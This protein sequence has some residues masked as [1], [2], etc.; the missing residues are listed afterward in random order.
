MNNIEVLTGKF[1]STLHNKDNWT[2]NDLLLPDLVSQECVTVCMEA[3]GM[4]L[5]WVYENYQY[6]DNGIF[7]CH[8][9]TVIYSTKDLLTLYSNL[10]NK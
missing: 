7:T 1:L 3:M 2:S 4:F 8:D 6:A 9:T 5:T 10:L